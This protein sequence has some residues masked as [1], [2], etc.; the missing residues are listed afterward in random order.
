LIDRRENEVSYLRVRTPNPSEFCERVLQ[1]VFDVTPDSTLEIIE[2]AIV[3][4]R[5]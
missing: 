5:S 3:S 2:E 4:P 1:Q